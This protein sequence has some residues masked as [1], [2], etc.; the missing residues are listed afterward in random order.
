MP[1]PDCRS[2]D[3]SWPSSPRSRSLSR[4]I[5]PRRSPRPIPTSTASSPTTPGPAHVPGMAWGV[6]VDGTARAHRHVRRAGHDDAGAGHARHR[7]PD[8]LDDQ[9]LHGRRDPRRCATPA[10]CRSTIPP[11]GTSPNSKALA[12]PTTDA[13]R[14]TI[15]HLLSHAAG[16]PEDNPWGDQQLALSDDQ[17]ATLMRQGIP[18]SNPPG[19]AYEYSN[20]GFA[21]LGRIVSKVSGMPYRDYVRTRV[22]EPLALSA[23]TL[24]APAVPPARLAHGYRWEDERWK[25]EPPLPDGAFGAMGGMLTSLARPVAL[26]R[27]DDG[28]LAGQRTAPRPAR[29]SVPRCAR[30]SRCGGARRRWPAA[31]QAA[32]S[33]CRRAATA[34]DCA[35]RRPASSATSSRTPAACRVLARRC[36]GTPNTASV[37][38]PWAH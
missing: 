5:A 27:L 36:A 17:M 24:D 7:V 2:P 13:P 14:I 8:R 38:S 29:C 32:D 11:S 31:R 1:P 12:Y 37:S 35:S 10:S 23:T 34:T 3:C 20:Y 19:L 30:C 22:L 15:R 6:I 33:P 28:G 26:R 21:I 9:E 4:L 25:E 18:F 16:F